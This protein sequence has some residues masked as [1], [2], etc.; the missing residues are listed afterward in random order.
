MPD[1]RRAAAAA[2]TPPAAVTLTLPMPDTL[3]NS[4][5]GRS[6]GWRA[7]ARAKRT[8]FARLD[9]LQMLGTL[10]PPPAVPIARARLTSVMHLG[11]AMDDD[12]AVARHKW[13]LDWLV[14]RG[15][16]ATDRRSGLRWAAFPEQV[17]SRKHA[18]ELILTITPLPEEG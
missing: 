8:Y 12:N 10:P 18:Y 3:T 17:V 4:G 6:R 5:R 15:Y 1:A 2:P 14:T 11:A 7:V 13:A 16:V 9:W